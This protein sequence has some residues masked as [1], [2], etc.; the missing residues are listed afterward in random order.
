ME[1]IAH[2]YQLAKFIDVALAPR[3]WRGRTLAAVP[4]PGAVLTRC[5]ET[6]RGIADAL[7]DERRAVDAATLS[8]LKHVLTRGASSQIGRAHV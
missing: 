5:A 7:R 8:E 3:T 4:I 6:M 1:A 2:R